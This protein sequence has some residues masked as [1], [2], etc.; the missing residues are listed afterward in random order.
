MRIHPYFF[1]IIK[2]LARQLHSYSMSDKAKCEL[3]D[4]YRL[5]KALQKGDQSA[6][7][8]VFNRYGDTLKSFARQELKSEALAEDAVQEIFC[9]LWMKR[10]QLDSGLSLQGFLFTCLK[11]HILNMIRTHKNE[12][13]KNYRFAYGQ[14]YTA[15]A[16]EEEV[17]G[18]EIKSRFN[19]ELSQLS[20]LKSKVLK[21]SVYQGL[22]NEQ[23]ARELNI[24]LNTVKM[25]LS[26]S[27]RQLRKVIELHG[28]KAIVIT[29]LQ[30]F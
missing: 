15:N 22:S 27:S 2:I 23:I 4:N 10:E 12:L 6:F 7:E 14:T 25:Y 19:L 20:E 17:I 11:N 26:Q 5:V 8:E 3:S 24:S 9:K 13:L 18:N 29:F 21:L 1:K 28:L 16:T 30:I